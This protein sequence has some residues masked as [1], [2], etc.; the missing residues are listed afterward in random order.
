MSFTRIIPRTRRKSIFAGLFLLS[1]L[2][3]VGVKYF[4]HQA[5]VAVRE[6][7]YTQ[8]RELADAGA[9]GRFKSKAICYG[10]EFRRRD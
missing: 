10:G 4:K 2:A 7:N 6:I 9:S 8:L 5:P 1:A 3:V